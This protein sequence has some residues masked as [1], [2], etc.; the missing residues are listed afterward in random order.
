MNVNTVNAFV[1]ETT[2]VWEYALPR[3][4]IR[5]TIDGTVPDR[6]ASLYTGPFLLAESADFNIRFFRPDG[7]AADIVK[8]SYRK[9][10]YRPSGVISGTKKPGLRCDW[11]EAVV[12][13]C[14]AMDTLPIR[15]TYTVDRIVIP[16]GV[17]ENV[18]FAIP[19]M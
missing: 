15:Q 6:H 12:N 14:A 19:V 9:Q 4:E 7:S 10:D 3:V 17:N 11:H 8:T 13:R 16:E 2:V 18:P 1:G 5:Y